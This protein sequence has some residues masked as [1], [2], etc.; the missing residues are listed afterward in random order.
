LASNA[1]TEEH[2]K[3]KLRG[4]FMAKIR[5]YS[6]N[7]VRIDVRKSNPP[8]LVVAVSGH[9][10]TSGWTAP[11]LKTIEK[12]VSPDGI[13]DLEL[14][15]EPPPRDTIVLEFLAPISAHLVWTKEV[16]KV[17]GVKILA[18]TND[19]TRLLVEQPVFT[20][21]ALGEEGIPPFPR[22]P[23]TTF[24]VGE[25]GPP[26]VDVRGSPFPNPK[27]AVG[28]VPPDEWLRQLET[29]MRSNPFGQR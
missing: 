15:A 10:T 26:P 5:A 29:L 27:V 9:V 21:Q 13:L 20:T 18:R 3:I 7:D 2:S 11:E 17:I 22:P 6:V 1:K 24:A 25:E 14:V 12:E 23:I 8:T 19:I 28:E 16:P 4:D